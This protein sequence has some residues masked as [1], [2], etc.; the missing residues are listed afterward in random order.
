MQRAPSAKREGGSRAA[1]KRAKK[2]K[3]D[4]ILK[5]DLDVASH[6]TK[7]EQEIPF[8]K[9]KLGIMEKDRKKKISGSKRNEPETD[10]HTMISKKKIKD[11]EENESEETTFRPEDNMRSKH[12]K[13]SENFDHVDPFDFG[14]ENSDEEIRQENDIVEKGLSSLSLGQILF[15]KPTNQEEEV[16]NDSSD[17]G[18]NIC[19]DPLEI[20]SRVSTVR[21][22][23]ILI[24]FLLAPSGIS[25]EEFYKTYW[26]K[27]PLLVS[28]SQNMADVEEGKVNVNIN[29]TH[30]N[31]KKN[32]KYSTK[33]DDQN[34]PLNVE[35]YRRRLD[36]ILNKTKIEELIENFPMRYGRD[37]NI[38][39]YCDGED[40]VSKR[41]HTLDLLPNTHSEVDD[42]DSNYIVAESADVWSNFSNG[43]TV[44]LL[45]PQK[46]NDETHSLL[47]ILEHEFGCMV[48]ANAYLTPGGRAPCQ[49]F[50]PH[51]DDIEAFI[52][53]LEG[54][55]HW[56][57]YP[58][59]S[60]AETLPRESSRDFTEDEIRE[61]KPVIDVELGPGDILYMPRG[62]IH[63]ANTCHGGK[64]SLHLT[65]SAMQNWSWVDLLDIIMPMALESAAASDTSY[66]LRQGLP[67][68]F[69][70]YMGVMYDQTVP[71]GIKQAV[72]ESNGM[73]TDDGNEN[74]NISLKKMQSKFHDEATTR[75]MRVCKEAL[76]LITA[77]CDQIGKR[78]LSD[79]LPPA[80]SN[81][82]SSLSSENR[83]ENGGKIWPNSMVR[84]IRPDIARLVLEDGKA[85]LYH[86]ADNSR[87]YH[88][89][90]L[91]PLEF[92]IDDAPAIEMLL[93]TKEPHWICVKD[94]IHGDIEDKMEITQSLYDE[95]ILALLPIN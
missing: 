90:P 56:R 7:T 73:Q 42:D 23:R 6:R 3:K 16:A 41:R 61:I 4:Q 93:T 5:N 79:R 50:A 19:N 81:V 94:L 31:E 28:L 71:E 68:N 70:S 1:K 40:G 85:I 64:H 52:L 39:K 66:N 18:S 48:G 29:D 74:K 35:N 91:S 15:P 69:I 8:Q 53:Q 80:F 75:I 12:E 14:N 51:Y 77:G 89:N 92:E 46:H 9:E 82:E 10:G 49:G 84:L 60:M 55:K 20:L 67:R 58:P 76:N 38:T 88:G 17:S 45:C 22:A 2:K 54:S 95:G 57:V 47:S 59:M 65:V 34:N 30:K 13:S 87:V 32:R 78:F 24:N 83:N 33:K 63:Q 44:R 36:G 27:R 37:L 21:K 11:D 43:C 25:A 62:W 86:C 72:G 26:E